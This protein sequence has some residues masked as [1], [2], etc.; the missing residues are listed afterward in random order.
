MDNETKQRIANLPNDAPATAVVA[1][2]AG[3]D[4]RCVGTPYWYIAPEPHLWDYDGSMGNPF[5]HDYVRRW[6]LDHGMNV[7]YNSPDL[8]TFDVY[9]VNIVPV[10]PDKEKKVGRG[11]DEYSPEAAFQVAVQQ[12][13][14]ALREEAHA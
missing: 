2:W 9:V 6:L 4:V 13:A 8:F 1:A 7:I 5:E 14:D 12:F 11:E 3:K 10:L